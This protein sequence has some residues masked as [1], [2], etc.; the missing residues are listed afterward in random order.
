MGSPLSNIF[1]DDLDDINCIFG[2]SEA[3]KDWQSIGG[4]TSF[5]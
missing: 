3:G 4:Q 5:S 1:T 2:W